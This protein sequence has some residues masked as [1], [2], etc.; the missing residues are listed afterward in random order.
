M[1]LLRVW[2]MDGCLV[3]NTERVTGNDFLENT[4]ALLQDRPITYAVMAAREEPPDSLSVCITSRPRKLQPETELWLRKYN[5][6]QLATHLI[7]RPSAL[8]LYNELANANFK[9]DRIGALL[10]LFSPKEVHL[11]DDV[12]ENLGKMFAR[13]TG[14]ITVKA[15]LCNRTSMSLYRSTT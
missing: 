11:Y 8:P 7:M 5:L 13:R 12:A 10:V 1:R 9:A 3:D 14:G 4:K 15:Y 6:P 2:D